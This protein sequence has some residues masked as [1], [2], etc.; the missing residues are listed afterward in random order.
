MARRHGRRRRLRRRVGRLRPR[1]RGDGE[2]G[3]D[4]SSVSDGAK[5][6]SFS[7]RP[8]PTSPRSRSRRTARSSA[9]PPRT[10]RSTASTRR[11]PGRPASPSEIRK[12][13]RSGRRLSRRTAR[14]TRGRATRGAYYRKAPSGAVRAL[15]RDRGRAHSR[16][17]RSDPT[18]PLYAGTSDR[19]LVI[20]TPVKGSPRTLH[21]LLPPEVTG[22]AVDD[23]GVVYAAASQLDATP[24]DPRRADVQVRSTPTP[25][26]RRREL[27]RRAGRL[28]CPP[29]RPAL[30]RQPS[31]ARRAARKSP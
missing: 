15:P 27:G 7:P 12:R 14:S 13:P 22:L 3:S 8:S 23:G 9:R 21:H 28:S 5:S 19:G 29:R 20:A 17:R 1:L 24:V 11:P 26:P 2:A 30:A 25:P 4:G 6:P 31:P 16:A 10:G 18:G